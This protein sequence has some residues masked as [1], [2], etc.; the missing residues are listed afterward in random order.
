MLLKFFFTGQQ[1]NNNTIWDSVQKTNLPFILTPLCP[2]LLFFALFALFNQ[3]DSDEST[4]DTVVAVSSCR[5]PSTPDALLRFEK[6]LQ[7]LCNGLADDVV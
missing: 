5:V 1:K 4:S 7:Q 3:V 2:F 6:A